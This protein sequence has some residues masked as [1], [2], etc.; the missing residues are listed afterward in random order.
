[1]ILIGKIFLFNLVIFSSFARVPDVSS[2]IYNATKEIDDITFSIRSESINELVKS[3][4]ANDEFK[5][6]IVTTF[7]YKNSKEI[8]IKTN[9]SAAK[10]IRKKLRELFYNKAEVVWGTDLKEWIGGY[11]FIQEQNKWFIYSDESGVLDTTEIRIRFVSKSLQVIEKK[12]TGT[13]RTTYE[14]IITDW[15]K[16]LLVLDRITR[17]VYEGN[18]SIKVT[19]NIEYK[20]IDSIGWVPGVLRAKT[21]QE[22]NMGTINKVERSFNEV[23]FFE[24]YKINQSAA[25]NWFSRK[26]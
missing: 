4:T 20:K 17:K 6:L 1:M 3:K 25:R 22:V 24:N 5:N 8:E 21:I 14:F 11:E 9:G 26:K 10:S 13:L 15:S 18:Q 23:F 7:K 19:N 12:P 2:R 16:G